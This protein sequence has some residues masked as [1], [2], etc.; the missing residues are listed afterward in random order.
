V[1][2][3]LISAGLSHLTV[4]TVSDRHLVAWGSSHGRG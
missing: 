3:Q 4:E 1:K 2:E